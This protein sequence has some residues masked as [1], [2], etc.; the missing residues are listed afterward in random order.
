MPRVKLRTADI[1]TPGVNQNM[2]QR[3]GFQ[4]LYDNGATGTD[5]IIGK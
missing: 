1:N 4:A 5:I 3:I 2:L